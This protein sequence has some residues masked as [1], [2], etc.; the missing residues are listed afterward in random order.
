MAQTEYDDDGSSHAPE[1]AGTTELARVYLQ[2]GQ[3]LEKNGRLPEAIS[4]YRKVLEI[5]PTW[6][7]ALLLLGNSL[8]HSGAFDESAKALTEAF[9]L[10]D[11]ADAEGRST[12]LF[13]LA[14]NFYDQKKYE[15]ALEYIDD[16]LA[17]EQ[18]ASLYSLKGDCLYL[19]EREAEALT[20]FDQAIKTDANFVQAW[21][22]KAEVLESLGRLIDALGAIDYALILDPDDE[23]V[24]SNKARLLFAVEKLEESVAV[25]DQILRTDPNNVQVRVGKSN[26]LTRLGRPQQALEIIDQTLEDN[27]Q[28]A[29]LLIKKG[30]LLTALGRAEEGLAYF[31]RVM[32][33][34][35]AGAQ[36]VSKPETAWALD[37]KANVLLSL[38]SYEEALALYDRANEL[39]ITQS[40]SDAHKAHLL[41][42]LERFPEALDLYDQALKSQPD[43][44]ILAGKAE[45]LYRMRKYDQTI[46][47]WNRVITLHPD[48]PEAYGRRGEAYRYMYRYE[49]AL[50]DLNHALSINPKIDWFLYQRFA[51]KTALDRPQ[52]ARADLELAIKYAKQL[53]VRMPDNW[54]HT[55]NLALY[56]LTAGQVVEAKRLYQEVVS[57]NTPIYTIVEAI[58]DLDD[59]ALLLNGQSDELKALLEAYAQSHYSRAATSVV[60]S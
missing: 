13:A 58:K 15:A 28:A 21:V 30:Q 45:T 22:G 44:W 32:E 19:L 26:V 17:L 31:D 6:S 51:V 39:G 29:H 25:Y 11:E 52:E 36:S 40:W 24:L 14:L 8:R 18:N 50:N 5:E 23:L 3:A 27:P 33:L 47:Y 57:A 16:A 43:A 10:T 20:A 37:H 54:M 35:K 49:D 2:L 53:H 46:E 59:N 48:A 38:G 7:A 12:V 56:D 34:S 60:S 42:Y 1:L 4:K 9:K 41:R 55:C